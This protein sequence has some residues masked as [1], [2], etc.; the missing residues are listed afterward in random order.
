V[1]LVV[2][3]PEEIVPI[4]VKFL[5]ESKILVP[6]TLITSPVPACVSPP[7]NKLIPPL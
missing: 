6:A 3:A 5:E 7:E 2:I 1:L 4:F